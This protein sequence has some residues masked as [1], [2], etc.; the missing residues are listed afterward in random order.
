[1]LP[2]KKQAKTA[3]WYGIFLMTNYHGRVVY[4]K[5]GV[6]YDSSH[7]TVERYVREFL[8]LST[9]NWSQRRLE[10]VQRVGRLNN[11]DG[12]VNENGKNK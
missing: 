4:S 9:E 6:G 1:M 12:D 7:T 5:D 8:N 11:D 10:G 2:E 3:R